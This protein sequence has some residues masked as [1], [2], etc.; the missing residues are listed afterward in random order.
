MIQINQLSKSFGRVDVLCGL[1][2]T[3]AH[4][5]MIVLLGPNGSGKSTLFRCML[6]LIG[7]DGDISI[8]NASPLTDGKAVRASIGFVPQQN[9]LHLDLTLEETLLFYSLLRKVDAEAAF[10]LLDKVNL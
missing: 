3:V 7:Y 5:E 10:K 4:G 1:D 9:G 6:G 2:L 8:N